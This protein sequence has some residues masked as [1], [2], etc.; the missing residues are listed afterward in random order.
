MIRHNGQ[1]HLE[2]RVTALEE[3]VHGLEGRLAALADAVRVLA[4]GLEDLPTI[5]PGQ[6]PAA[7]AARRAYDLLL[8]AEPRPPDAQRA[9]GHS[10]T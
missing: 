8:V 7:E 4:H 9:A 6:K 3:R 2:S 10:D 5:E 1:R